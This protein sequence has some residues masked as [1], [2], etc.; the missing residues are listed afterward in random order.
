LRPRFSEN[1][2]GRISVFSW[3]P[4]LSGRDPNVSFESEHAV[5]GLAGQGCICSETV[6]EFARALE[7]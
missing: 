5:F 1:R 3:S 6:T 7:L 4:L 2:A